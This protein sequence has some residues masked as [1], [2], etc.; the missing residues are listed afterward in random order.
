MNL[1]AL[2]DALSAQVSIRQRPGLGVPGPAA[3][4]W[5]WGMGLCEVGG[6]CRD[7]NR[8]SPG[9]CVPCGR[10][11]QGADPR[12]VRGCPGRRSGKGGRAGGRPTGRCTCAAAGAPGARPPCRAG[13]GC[14]FRGAAEAS[15][16]VPGVPAALP[17]PAALLGPR[18]PRR[19]ARARWGQGARAAGGGHRGVPL[20][21]GVTPAPQIPEGLE[22]PRGERPCWLRHGGHR[23]A[24][25]GGGGPRWPSVRGLEVQVRGKDERP[26]HFLVRFGKLV[27]RGA[28]GLFPMEDTERPWPLSGGRSDP[29][30]AGGGR[31]GAA[32]SLPAKS[33]FPQMRAPQLSGAVSSSLAVD[34]LRAG[35]SV[36]LPD[37]GL[38]RLCFSLPDA[39]FRRSWPIS[40]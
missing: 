13:R 33:F 5:A 40:L 22:G 17:A 20:E 16:G 4:A 28:V 1:V 8:G 18:G 23:A 27:R 26:G 10:G 3:S 32:S 2:I 29:G 30:G 38:T 35:G 24:W 6:W 9:R 7:G 21:A 37:R 31:D 25:R 14:R 19:R 15:W 34:P 12:G 36:P 11:R 39:G